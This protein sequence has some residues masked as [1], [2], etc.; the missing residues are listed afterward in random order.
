MNHINRTNKDKISKIKH[1]SPLRLIMNTRNSQAFKNDSRGCPRMQP[2]F[3][4]SHQH[5][6]DIIP[7]K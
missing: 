7:V 4:R 3:L 6:L 2:D 1:R 5:K